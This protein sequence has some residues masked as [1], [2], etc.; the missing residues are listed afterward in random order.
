GFDTIRINV[1][2]DGSQLWLPNT[3]TPNADGE[4]DFFYPHGKGISEIKR[5]RIYDRWGELIF[6]RTNMPLN[7]KNAGWNGT[8][9]NQQLKPDVFVWVLN[10]VCSNGTPLEVKGNISLIR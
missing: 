8:Y 2:C 7:D 6:D 5:F 10:A 9:K 1:R 3:F 4:N